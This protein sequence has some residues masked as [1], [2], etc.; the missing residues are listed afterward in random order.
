[1]LPTMST[2]SHPG[3][4]VA[5]TLAYTLSPTHTTATAWNV[6]TVAMIHSVLLSAALA[7]STGLSGDGP[8][9]LMSV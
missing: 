3:A 5:H 6:V 7:G 9:E 8:A 2:S 4:L 1:M